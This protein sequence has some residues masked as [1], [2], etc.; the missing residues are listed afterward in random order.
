MKYIEK[1]VKILTLGIFCFYIGWFS[2]DKDYIN[3]DAIPYVA[4]A[5]LVQTPNTDIA[6]E[7]SWRLLK[8]TVDNNI[9]Q[10]LCCASDY[11]KSM[12]SDKSAFVSHLP[13]YQ[14]KSGYIYL[15]RVVSN[16]FHINEYDAIKVISQISSILIVFVMAISF[17]N[18]RLPI[19]LSIFPVLLLMEIL[20]LSRL[21]TP[22]ALI[23]LVMLISAYL[24][25]KN[26]F[27]I[28]C[29]VLIFS[30]LL[31]QT[32]IIFV[33]IFSFAKLFKKQYISFFLL[34]F[35]S[36][37]LYVLNSLNFS[38][39]GYWKTFHS[40]LIKMPNTFIDYNPEF[41][42]EIYLGLLIDK[43]LWILTDPYLSKLVILL[44]MNVAIGFFFFQS[45]FNEISRFGQ[46]SLVFSIGAIIAFVLIPFPDF[47]I[48]AGPIIASS[49]LILK[50]LAKTRNLES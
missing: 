45:K 14:T 39:I 37:C 18:E 43:F 26:K 15:I 47:R 5:S 42:F 27:L 19:Y 22:D 16:L 49:Y 6:F 7:Y 20:Q 35:F 50:A 9:Y 31:R 34:S 3:Y 46:L 40:S 23:G 38:S 24:L 21:M 8:E 12:S 29:T 44:G 17:F 2:N 32:N 30:I 10:D 33:G 4:S 41:S 13:S 28:A 25:S 1:I 48:Y 11:R 36:F